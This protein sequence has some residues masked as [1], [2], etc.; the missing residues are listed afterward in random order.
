M[1]RRTFDT[2]TIQPGQLLPKGLPIDPKVW[3]AALG[4]G[5]RD[6]AVG[7]VD[8]KV[9]FFCGAIDTTAKATFAAVRSKTAQ[10]GKL[11]AQILPKL[12]AAPELL[13]ACDVRQTL[14]DLRAALP[15]E[16]RQSLPDV[17][18]GDPVLVWAA[19]SSG[20]TRYELQL[21]ADIVPLMAMFR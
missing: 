11:L 21:H 16:A 5:K 3:T 8:Q 4:T 18:T 15:K 12:H 6:I 17:S 20:G 13:I 14:R 1:I 7:I 2:K 10:P 19:L 9:G